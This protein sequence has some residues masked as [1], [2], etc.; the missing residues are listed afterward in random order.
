M[1]KAVS[2]SESTPFAQLVEEANSGI[3]FFHNHHHIGSYQILAQS[4]TGFK[5]AGVAHLYLEI[6]KEAFSEILQ[7]HSKRQEPIFMDKII[8]HFK[9]ETA[10]TGLRQLIE[11]AHQAGIRVLAVDSDKNIYTGEN[12]AGDSK[13][14]QRII[15]KR[16]Q[17]NTDIVKNILANRRLL[18]SHE[19]FIGLFGGNHIDICKGKLSDV[20]KVLVHSHP[21]TD[22]QYQHCL[23]DHLSSA[24]ERTN[25]HLKKFDIISLVKEDLEKDELDLSSPLNEEN[26]NLN[27]LNRLLSS[28]SLPSAHAY[29]RKKSGKI[30]GVIFVSEENYPTVWQKM[31]EEMDPFP[32]RFEHDAASCRIIISDIGQEEFFR[33]VV[34]SLVQIAKVQIAKQNT[35][36]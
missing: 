18:T 4:M 16:L 33:K 27:Y 2:F 19:K 20:T 6:A 11:A 22:S 12:L 1:N 23:P 25:L 30:D 21:L 7:M 28:L 32:K 13:E 8:Q 26:K 17:N 35:L 10:Q 24:D 3:F 34:L 15:M 31:V 36:Q 29:K 14:S 9:D 5:Q